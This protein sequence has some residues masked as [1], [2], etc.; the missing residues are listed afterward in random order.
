MVDQH[1]AEQLA[2]L[3][4]RV[5]SLH[6]SPAFSRLMHMNLSFSHLKALRHVACSGEV[7]MKDL[8]EVLEMTPP[9]VTALVRRLEY[10]GL[11]KRFRH[12]TDSR[13]WLLGLTDQ[14]Q[15]LMNALNQQRLLLMQQLLAQLDPTEQQTLLEL[16]ERAV[17]AAETLITNQ[18]IAEKT[19]DKSLPLADQETYGDTCY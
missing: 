5:R 18:A 9:S 17:T 19:N 16:L 3:F 12:A 2:R 15:A 4:E 8:A 14:G 11:L 7:P 6:T 13:I 10:T 1:S